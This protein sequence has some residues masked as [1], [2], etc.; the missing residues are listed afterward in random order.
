MS[1]NGQYIGV[2]G[3]TDRDK[4][5]AS[6]CFFEQLVKEVRLECK[7]MV[8]VLVSLKTLNGKKNKYP[9]RYPEIDYIG[10][11]FD[12]AS[13][14]PNSMKIIHYNTKK[15]DTLNA[16][17]MA[18]TELIGEDNFDGFQLNIAWPPLDELE[19]Y[20]KRYPDKTIILQ[21]GSSATKIFNNVQTRIMP[22]L[23]SYYRVMDYI[24]LDPSGGIGKQFN[25]DE[26]KSYID[27][28]KLRTSL[29]DLGIIVAGGLCANS[30]DELLSPI[31]DKYPDISIDAEGLLRDKDDCLSL[32]KVKRYIKESI[33]LFSEAKEI[34]V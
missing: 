7:F 20:K 30:A 15:A 1:K 18:L 29:F 25:I 33:Y 31:L 27:C 28:I 12:G 10:N 14:I 17:L 26:M 9:N 11:I 22:T 24:L 34:N 32:K 2:T 13:S 5:F 23:S 4:V 6:L 3:F 16:Q 21:V 8:G 19:V